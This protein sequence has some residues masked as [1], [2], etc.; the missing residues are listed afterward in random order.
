MGMPPG[1]ATWACSSVQ[2]FVVLKYGRRTRPLAEPL[3]PAIVPLRAA[4]IARQS[5]PPNIGKEKRII[6]D[7]IVATVSVD[8][9]GV[10]DGAEAALVLS[11]VGFNKSS[12]CLEC[13]GQEPSS[14]RNNGAAN[15]MIFSSVA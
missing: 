8:R 12:R 7:Y 15:R 9:A 13:G 3:Q 1:C 11:L 6:K 10:L 14:L 4:E 2:C 5:L